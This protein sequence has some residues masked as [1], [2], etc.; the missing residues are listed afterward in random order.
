MKRKKKD[1]PVKH[2]QKKQ[3]FL[4]PVNLLKITLNEYK[5]WRHSEYKDIIQRKL[6]IIKEEFTKKSDYWFEHPELPG[7]ISEFLELDLE[8]YKLVLQLA[9]V[10]FRSN[11]ES[12]DVKTI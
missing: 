2:V 12:P 7:S 10:N 5:V 9:E 4:P 1:R 11:N 8:D 6:N 3:E